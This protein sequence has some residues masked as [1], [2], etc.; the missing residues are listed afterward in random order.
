MRQSLGA[1]ALAAI[2]VA[3]I[4][5]AVGASPLME[6]SSP[7]EPISARISPVRQ[8]LIYAKEGSRKLVDGRWNLGQSEAKLGITLSADEKN[9]LMA[10][11]G[12]IL[13][14]TPDIHNEDEDRI[15]IK[16][17]ATAVSVLR[18]DLLVTAKHVFFKGKRAVVPFGSCSF[19]S[20]SRRNVAVPILVEKDQRKGYVFNNE[21][22]IVVRLKRE[23]EGCS[24]FAL[25][26]YD[27]SLREGEQILSVTGRQRR[28]LNRI[29]GRELVVAKGKI[30]RILDGV[31]GG[32][33]FY[34]A[35]IDFDVGGSGGAVFALVDGRPVS[36]DEGRLV[37]RGISVAN[38]P[39]AK[40][41]RPYSDAQ[42]YTIVIGLQAEFRELVKGKAN[43]PAAMEPAPCGQGGAAKINVISDSVASAQ[44]ETLAALL[45]QHGC[46]REATPDRKANAKCTEL[47]KGLKQAAS[48]RGK[49]ER[50]TQAREFRLKNDTSCRICFTY[51][52][53]N[54]YGCWDQAVSLSGKSVL[55]AG[56]R[57]RAPVIENPQFCQSGQVLAE[58]APS[59]PPRRPALAIDA[60]S[61]PLP[62]RRPEQAPTAAADF[63]KPAVDPE[64]VFLAA[65]EK[66]K[67]EGVYTLTSEDIRGLSLEQ[68]RE[69]RGY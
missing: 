1:G 36:D 8:A 27:A 18:P 68:I 16:F 54:D 29:S 55:F 2:T 10:C 19:R 69:L 53:C 17:T 60:D 64:A 5:F 33:P 39:H 3:A 9:Q 42:N 21:D 13:C 67:R 59:L 25:N 37:L 45:Q 32:P 62:P 15:G 23:L 47:A 48:Q 46:S 12:Q 7:S 24:S 14:A 26:R 66:A 51:D 35:D 38:G 11:T 44:S 58:A 4:S 22:F 56:V 61:P 52:R 65:K 43:K 41:G 28:T 40:S 31:L 34:Y 49:Q 50:A 30:R 57:E 63:R 20:F 6:S